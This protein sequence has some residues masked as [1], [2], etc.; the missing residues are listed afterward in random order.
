MVNKPVSF[1]CYP[2]SGLSPSAIS[3][4]A[5]SKY[6]NSGG[7]LLAVTNFTVHD[8]YN[9]SGFD[10]DISLL[11]LNE[12]FPG[13]SDIGTISLASV[14]PPFFLLFPTTVVVSGFGTI[15]SGGALASQLM[16][17]ELYIA[18]P[19]TC[20]AAYL[21]SGI[22]ITSR[23]ICAARLGKDACQGDSGGPLTYNETLVG[24]VSFGIGCANPL[25]PG[26]YTSIPEL[27]SWILSIVPFP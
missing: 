7:R 26:V 12:T 13:S 5:G 14:T 11:Q 23:M 21:L 1:T 10:Y 3:V 9:S 8:L 27:L 15:S 25:L 18:S 19:I 24:V 4:R 2:S 17:A 16:Q 6:W 20:S 22:T